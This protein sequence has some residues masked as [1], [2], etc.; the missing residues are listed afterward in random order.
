MKMKEN[1]EVFAVTDSWAWMLE[2]LDAVEDSDVALYKVT[3]NGSYYYSKRQKTSPDGKIRL[4]RFLSPEQAEKFDGG[5]A[6]KIASQAT[7]I[8]GKLAAVP[9]P[10]MDQFNTNMQPCMERH[11]KICAAIG[12]ESGSI[13]ERCNKTSNMVAALKQGLANSPSTSV[14]S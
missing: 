12:A 11:G 3:P 8:E 7:E 2:K 6:K 13:L 5:L 1:F 14:T 9:V 10:D 4:V